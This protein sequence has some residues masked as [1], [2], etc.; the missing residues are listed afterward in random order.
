M[1]TSNKVLNDK[2]REKYLEIVSGALSAKGEEVL[3]VKYEREGKI[4]EA[5]IKTVNISYRLG[6]TNIEYVD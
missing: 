4:S 6:V 3:V 5:N 1:A 2:L